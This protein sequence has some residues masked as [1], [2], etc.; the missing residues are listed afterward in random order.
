MLTRLLCEYRMT[1]Y[2]GKISL[3]TTSQSRV[4]CQTMCIPFGDFWATR[5]FPATQ[6]PREKPE[7]S[8]SM[9]SIEFFFTRLRS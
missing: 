3:M 6:W 7:E 8:R 9:I 2:I 1:K 4:Q 5:G